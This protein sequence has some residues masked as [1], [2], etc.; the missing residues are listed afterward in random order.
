VQPGLLTCKEGI[1]EDNELNYSFEWDPG[2]AISNRSK[3]GVSF[4]Q[5]ATVFRDPKMISLAD[6]EHSEEEDR[7]IT[8]GMGNLAI[9]LVVIH[10][11]RNESSG[12]FRIRIISARKATGDEMHQYA[13]Y[14]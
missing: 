8:I 4:E 13:D 3:H 6:D 11:H 14:G 5:A 9:L 10:T 12:N 7:W 2:K 1:H